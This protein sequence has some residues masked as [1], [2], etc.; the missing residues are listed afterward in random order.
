MNVVLV[1]SGPAAAA[2]AD[3]AEDVGAGVS[4]GDVETLTDADL[5]VVTGAAGASGFE[6]AN[7]AALAG[8]TPW[9]AVE[10]GGLGGH[11]VPDVEAA[12]SGFAPSTAC[13]ECLR[14]RVEAGGATT[15][16]EPAVSAPSARLGGAL[17]GRELARLLD[18]EESPVVGGVLEVP[19]A[20]RMLL[21]VPGCEACAEGRER[22]LSVTAAERGLDAALSAAER[23]VDERVGPITEVG[24][25]ESFPAPYYL[26]RL[27]DTTGFSDRQAAQQ[28]AG[29]AEGWDEA[30]MKSLGEALE[31]Y[32]AGVYR[33]DSLRQAQPG[34][35]EGMVDPGAFVGVESTDEAVPWVEATDLAAWADERDPAAGQGAWLPA[36]FVQFPPPER[37]FGSPITTGLGLGNGAVGALLSGLYEVVERDATMLAWYSTFEPLGL[38]VEADGYRTLAGRAASEGLSVTALLVTQDVDVPVVAAA[39]HRDGGEWPRF[40]AGS[41]AGLDPT[42]AA[43]SALSE[44]LQNW[45]EL[46]S[47]GP[48]AAADES[49]AI[50]RYAEFPTAARE[51]VDPETTVP[52]DSVGPAE[53]P[54]GEAEL[55]AVVDRVTGAGLSPYAARTTTRDV[56]SLGFEAVRAV[57]PSAQPLFTDEATF[58]ERAREVPGELGFEPRLDR[59]HHPFP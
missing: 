57:V 51:F 22:S 40:A 7:E 45:M 37:R 20:R 2:V 17:A 46:R 55:A 48:E 19:H 47:M 49:G 11:P 59:E 24:E 25:A 15:T 58:G 23:A 53:V 32:C 50:G 33:T 26:A 6:A 12:V 8:D 43:T 1:G 27:A 18:G 16:G 9:L 54:A 10:G 13:F 29:V 30:F 52:A 42:A 56:A 41:G 4:R 28:A 38:A 5:G 34:T 35:V 36:E 3:A 31:R 14:T 39:V 21:P 44:A